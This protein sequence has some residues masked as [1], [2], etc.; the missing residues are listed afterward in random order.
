MP[1]AF[2]ELQTLQAVAADGVLRQHA[3]DG[4]LH[5][6]FRLLLHQ[7]TILDFL[8]VA[9]PAGVVAVVLI[10]RLVAGQNGLVGVDD[11]D[12]SPQSTFGV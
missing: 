11:D 8:Q 9:D 5:G 7:E 12:K 1:G 6:K 10:L 2:V 3:F 4:Q